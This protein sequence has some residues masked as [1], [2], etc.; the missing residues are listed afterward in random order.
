MAQPAT[1]HFPLDQ[2]ADPL[3]AL[4][5]EPVISRKR[6]PVLPQT[7]LTRL[8]LWQGMPW[9]ERRVKE[10]DREKFTAGLEETLLHS[11]R[12]ETSAKMG[13]Q[14]QSPPCQSMGRT[15]VP[16]SR[17][18]TF[19]GTPQPGVPAAQPDST[20]RKVS[21]SRAWPARPSDGPAEQQKPSAFGS[22]VQLRWASSLL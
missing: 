16:P 11:G 7:H 13:R 14:P 6:C 4:I 18:Y 21:H 3:A 17:H 20:G 5:T 19:L 12:S 2:R 8:S 22:A 9:G 1:H 15:L 10:R